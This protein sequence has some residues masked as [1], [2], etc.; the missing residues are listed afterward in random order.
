MSVN[1]NPNLLTSRGGPFAQTRTGVVVGEASADTVII[2]VGGTQFPARYLASYVPVAGDLVAISLQDSSWMVYGRIAGQGSNQVAGGSFENDPIGSTPDGWTLYDVAGLSAVDVRE[3]EGAPSGNQV[4]AVYPLAPA[5]T[6]LLYSPPIS[7]A[8]GQVWD[9]GAFVGGDYEVGATPDADADLVA[10]WFA[11]TTNL[12]PTTSAADTLVASL[13]DVTQLP[14]FTGMSGSV[15]VPTGAVVM[16]VALRS[17]LTTGQALEWDFVTARPRQEGSGAGPR[18]ALA[19]EPI[20]V[21]T[22]AVTT[23]ETVGITTDPITFEPGRAYKVEAAGFV[24][25][26]AGGDTVRIRVKLN[27]TGGQGLIDTFG[28]MLINGANGMWTFSHDR[29]FRV[30]P[31]SAPITDVLVM[32]Y[33]RNS[34][35]GNVF[36][37]ATSAN[38]AYLHVLDIGPESPLYTGAR[39]IV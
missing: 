28:T 25:S 3:R 1:P 24:Q 4:A 6:S 11:N 22:G 14:P 20:S 18:G 15:T 39:T 27:G 9:L 29:I 16:R 2:L 30:A 33:N 8:P 17:T 5:A 32:T 34:G 21:S 23:T 36:L 12:Y 38:P 10:L 35:A 31:G 26:S 7:V 37:G 19:F 13:T